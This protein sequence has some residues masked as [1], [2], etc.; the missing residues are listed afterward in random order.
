MSVELAEVVNPRLVQ[1][2]LR[3]DPAGLREALPSATLLVPALAHRDGEIVVQTRRGPR[4]RT[5]VCAFTDLEALR[6]W[7]RHPANAAVALDCAAVAELVP[8]ATI[9]LNPAGP[10]AHLLDAE[11]LTAWSGASNGNGHRTEAPGTVALGDPGRRRALREQANHAHELARRTAA[12]GD[13]SAACE[14]LQPAIQACAELGDQL[15]GAAAALELARWRAG[16]GS[17]RLALAGWQEAAGTTAALGEI[18][19]ALDALLDAAELAADNGLTAEAE[20]LSVTALDLAA[21]SD[22]S[23]RLISL[24][25]TLH[26]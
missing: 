3:R 17:I 12:S 18:D 6:A 25:R 7:D 10:G 2:L 4:G 26:A 23:D 8:E 9:A 14:Q 13:L 16:T 5:L 19:L 20:T 22:F 11:A 24:W 15:H 21:G 1:A